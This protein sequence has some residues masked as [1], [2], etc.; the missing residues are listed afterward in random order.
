MTRKVSLIVFVSLLLTGCASQAPAPVVKPPL[1]PPAAKPMSLSQKSFHKLDQQIQC[2]PY[3]REVSGIPI[4]GDAYTWW[5]QAEAMGYK[6]GNKPQ[7]GAVFVLS[8]TPRLRY[9]HLSV[10]KR[11]VDKRHIEVEHTNWGGNLATRCIV[12]KEMPVVDISKNN[13]WTSVRFWD[14]PSESY[15]SVYRGSGFIYQK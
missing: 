8:Q 15:G 7:P 13:D 1:K 6:R 2:V 3:A 5:N 14:Y 9:G 11:I 4:R 12:Y 10:V